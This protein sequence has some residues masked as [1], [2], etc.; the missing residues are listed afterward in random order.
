MSTKKPSTCNDMYLSRSH[1]TDTLSSRLKC[2]CRSR[3]KLLTIHSWPG[4]GSNSEKCRRFLYT[5]QTSFDMS[6][7]PF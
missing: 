5:K 4:C 3:P 6:D 2:L 7:W 1:V